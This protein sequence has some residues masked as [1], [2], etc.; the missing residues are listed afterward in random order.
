M[1]FSIIIPTYNRTAQLVSCIERLNA[2]IQNF[3]K[4]D[5]EIIVSDD[6]VD[7]DLKKILSDN[8]INVTWIKGLKR[9]PASNR[10]NGAKIAKGDWLIFLDDDVI[11]DFKLLSS[12]SNAIKNYLN[13]KA[14]EGAI[15]PDNWRLLDEDMAEC[16]I[17]LNGG[18][19]WSANI[20][21]NKSMFEQVDGFDEQFVIAAQEDQDIY[22]RLKELTEVQFVSEAFVIHPV[23]IIPFL[24][25]I[26]QSRAS[27]INWLKYSQK[28]NSLR[29]TIVIGIN[30]QFFAFF[31][32]FRKHR[33]K[34]AICSLFML[35]I[36]PFIVL[37]QKLFKNV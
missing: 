5:F 11:P 25:K 10:N 12:Y 14:F 7:L 2:D 15:H 21:I 3:S 18:V 37:Q 17:N 22:D 36:F 30:S 16:P 35:I 27:I 23:R 33:Y 20:C 32:N 9:G 26:K 24:N 8:Y 1:L 6:S 34:T 28:Y 19:F 4:D 31:T 29:S 13:S